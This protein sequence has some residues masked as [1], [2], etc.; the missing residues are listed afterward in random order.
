MDEILYAESLEVVGTSGCTGNNKFGTSVE[1][2]ECL[3]REL[4]IFIIG[5]AENHYVGFLLH[6]GINTLLNRVE[7]D[8]IDN[9]VAGT[10]KEIG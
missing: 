10:A 7:S 1:Q 8:I 3:G 4:R 9:F 5:R 6:G 2:L